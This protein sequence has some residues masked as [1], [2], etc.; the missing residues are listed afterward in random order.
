MNDRTLSIVLPTHNGAANLIKVVQECLAVAPRYCTDYEVIIVDDGSQDATAELANN[1]AAT[2]DP[3][4]VIHLPRP[5]GYTH[6][7]LSGWSAARG[8]YVL[9][10]DMEGAIGSGELA[11]L[12]PYIG[13]YAIV[14]GYR[15]RPPARERVATRLANLLLGIDVR[16]SG[17][18]FSLFRADLLHTL[19]L[20]TSAPWS[21]I[22]IFARARRHGVSCIQVG[23][24]A[25]PRPGSARRGPGAWDLARLWMRLR[26]ALPS[27]DTPPARPLWKQKAALGAGLAAVAW[28]FWMLLRRL[29]IAGQP[30]EAASPAPPVDRGV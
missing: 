19:N 30:P 27:D 20:D 22:E 1:L 29:L 21:A 25:Q 14:A 16:D 13:Q 18:H 24:N 9:A 23:V 8:D 10:L 15:L 11:R 2:C 3:V 7:L 28:G 12:A 5:R 4:M 26:R 6:A 17:C